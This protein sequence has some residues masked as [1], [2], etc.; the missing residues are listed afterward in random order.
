[1]FDPAAADVRGAVGTE[2][3]AADTRHGRDC[4]REEGVAARS[5]GLEVAREDGNDRGVRLDGH[6]VVGA[7]PR[8]VDGVVSDV[9]SHV[10]DRAA[11]L[12][13]LPDSMFHANPGP[14][15]EF[16]AKQR[17]PA[18]YPA[19]KFVEAGGLM[20]YAPNTIDQERRAATYIAKLFQ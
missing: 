16:A 17:L 4:G 5:V 12:V 15:I 6:D 14:I 7:E 8:E 3:H 9:G 20:S 2:G 1:E 18:V 11:G 10:K 19:R 13:V